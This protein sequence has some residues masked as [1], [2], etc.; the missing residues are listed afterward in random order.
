M[1]GPVEDPEEGKEKPPPALDADDIA[2]LKTYVRRLLLAKFK[3]TQH[4]LVEFLQSVFGEI[5]LCGI[6]CGCLKVDA[7]IKC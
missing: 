6:E 1:P 2:L 5:V 4:M 7:E 3:P